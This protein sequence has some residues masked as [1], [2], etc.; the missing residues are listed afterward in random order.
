MITFSS[1]I[2]HSVGGI[3]AA[4]GTSFVG[5]RREGRT[6]K[7][8][9]KYFKKIKKIKKKTNSSSWITCFFR[10]SWIEY[11]TRI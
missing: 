1:F 4:V 9:V 6:K 10:V 5:T 11:E 7:K 2:F 3:A 8:K